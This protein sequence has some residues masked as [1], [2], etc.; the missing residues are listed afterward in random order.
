MKEKLPPT[1]NI[2]HR[3]VCGTV[4]R[5]VSRNFLSFVAETVR[6]NAYASYWQNVGCNYV[7]TKILYIDTKIIDYE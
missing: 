6:C 7:L 4:D 3:W 2:S 1:A 5:N